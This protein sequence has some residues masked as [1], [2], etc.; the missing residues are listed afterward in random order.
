MRTVCIEN[1][2]KQ[3]KHLGR[4]KP[5]TQRTQETL[6]ILRSSSR[7]K[8]LESTS[9]LQPY[10]QEKSKCSG[11]PRRLSGLTC[12]RKVPRGHFFLILK[13]KIARKKFEIKASLDLRKA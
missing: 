11:G 5:A 6:V 12:R 9:S 7:E 1:D 2:I 3:V 10:L 8:S 13:S 4:K